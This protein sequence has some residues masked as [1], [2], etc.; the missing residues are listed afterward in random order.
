MAKHGVCPWWIGYL[1]ASPIRRLW[2]NPAR[3]LPPYVRVGMTVLEP[4]P[5]MGFFTLDIARLVGPSGRV[6]TVDVQPR[7]I[8]AL[9]RRARRDGLLDRID[10]RVVEAGSMALAGL[11]GSIDFVFACAVVHEWPSSA[12]FFAEA[13][14]AM[15]TGAKLLLAEPAGHVTGAEFLEQIAAAERNGLRLIDR[16]A[17]ARCITAL[18]SKA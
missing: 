1:L 11:D 15:K 16:P 12:Q 9:R 18:L 14:R 8:E 3:I 7:M 13:A 17:L 2:Q 6:V 5:G 4:G 10:A